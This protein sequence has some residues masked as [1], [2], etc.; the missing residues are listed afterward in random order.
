MIERTPTTPEAVTDDFL[1][2]ASASLEASEFAAI[3]RVH[4]PLRQVWA[5]G[6]WLASQL[7]AAGID[8][9]Q[10]ERVAFAHGQMCLGRDPWA[11]CAEILSSIA[12]GEAL[13]KPGR[14]LSEQ[15]KAASPDG[16][17]SAAVAV[18]ADVAKL[19]DAT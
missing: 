16:L 18:L 12:A 6:N 3:A 15:L 17:T 1:A 8:K 9:E 13:P 2:K 14:E 11:V 4:A 5:S 10:A 7:D 19:G